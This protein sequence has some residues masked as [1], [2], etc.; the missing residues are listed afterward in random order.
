MFVKSG[1]LRISL[2]DVNLICAKRANSVHSYLLRH[3]CPNVLALENASYKNVKLYT[4]SCSDWI[5]YEENP[6][7]VGDE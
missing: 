3:A 6:V 1:N 7:A 4:G 2:F 5:S